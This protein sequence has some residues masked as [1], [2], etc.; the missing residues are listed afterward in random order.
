MT[1]SKIQ[2]L[3][4][5]L[6]TNALQAENPAYVL[7]Q[8]KV[9][10]QISLRSCFLD[11]MILSKEKAIPCIQP[12]NIVHSLKK[13]SPLLVCLDVKMTFPQCKS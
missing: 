11:G 6:S 2:L 13:T 5:L 9:I 1:R 10:M 12:Q 8:P 4:L 7:I 3:V